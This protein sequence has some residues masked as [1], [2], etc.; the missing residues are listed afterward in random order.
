MKETLSSIELYRDLGFSLITISTKNKIGLDAIQQVLDI[1][2]QKRLAFTGISGVGKS[3]LIN[4]FLPK[5]SVRTQIV[6]DRTGQGRQTTSQ[7]F[8]HLYPENSPRL[9][10][11]D[12]P[13]VQNFGVT[14][15]SEDQVKAA[16]GEFNFLSQQCKFSGCWHLNEPKCAVTLA[17]SENR[18]ATSRYENYKDMLIE[19]RKNLDY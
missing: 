9:F 11:I 16:F 12:M 14:H 6:S 18:I 7:S 2:G 8:A 3:S 10:L 5:A 19:S 4:Y 1:E 15:L 13:G 17:L